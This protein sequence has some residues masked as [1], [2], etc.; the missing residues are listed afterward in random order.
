MPEEGTNE[1]LTESTERREF[2]RQLDHQHQYV[3][4]LELS[5]SLARRARV[6]NGEL[7]QL[8]HRIDA[9]RTRL[10]SL[11]Q[12]S[13]G[14]IYGRKRP[15]KLKGQSGHD[16]CVVYLDECGSHFA[17]VKPND[18]KAFVLAAAIVKESN[19]DLIDR[20]V[21][22]WKSH[23]WGHEGVVLHE[24]EIRHRKKNW[25]FGGDA[26]KQSDAEQSLCRLL[27]ELPFKGVV[28]VVRRDPYLERYG[29]AGM[30]AS[31]P[32]RL[33]HMALNFL[34]ERLVQ[35]LDAE[36][37]GA[38]G[39]IIAES[40]GPRE[41]AELQHEY[42]RLHLEGTSYVSD[43]F[44][45]STLGPAIDFQLK[46]A[47]LAGLQIADLLARTCGDKVL[48]PASEPRMWPVFLPS[49]VKAQKTKNSPLGL[50]ICPW[51]ESL[52]SLWSG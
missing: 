15:K 17:T 19:I 39:A 9:A 44:F 13:E 22:E 34:C 47:N 11:S 42:V 35:A 8:Q 27:G 50:K 10:N 29:D 26:N 49:L 40:R 45:R 21:A 38:R 37:Q 6:P 4:T 25:S 30:D 52:S 7:D 31:L 36:F 18:Y 3:Q 12:K 48:N 1:E 2:R 51:D 43:S 5:H 14:T 32:G 28:V 33:Y 20:R 41:D 46:S 16:T 23:T 24:P